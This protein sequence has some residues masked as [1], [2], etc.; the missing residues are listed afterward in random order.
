MS[1]A[2]LA[3]QREGS[4]GNAES[5]L[6]PMDDGYTGFLPTKSLSD[7][8][9]LYCIHHAQCF[10]FLNSPSNHHVPQPSPYPSLPNLSAS[11]KTNS[12]AGR[13]PPSTPSILNAGFGRVSSVPP[14]LV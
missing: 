1:R 5:S 7:H 4:R 11:S 14:K 3:E 13:Y 8:V 2:S 6:A 9:L 12:K 10:T